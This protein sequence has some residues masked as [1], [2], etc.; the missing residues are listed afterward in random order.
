MSPSPPADSEDPIGSSDA[1]PWSC[2]D[3]SDAVLARRYRQLDALFH[4]GVVRDTADIETGMERERSFQVDWNRMSR[5]KLWRE[6]SGPYPAVYEGTVEEYM[7]GRISRGGSE[8]EKSPA[9]PTMLFLWPNGRNLKD[10]SI[11][12]QI[13][14]FFR[15]M[16]RH[17]KPY[18][19]VAMIL[20]MS[21]TRPLQT[22]IVSYVAQQ[23]E[24]NPTTVPIWLYLTSTFLEMISKTLYWWYEM[25]VPLN[26]Q[27]VQ[28][29]SVL[30][31]KRTSLP[32]DHPLAIKWP[33][34]RFTGLLKDVDDVVNNVW[35]SCLS[36]FDDLVSIIYLLILCFSNLA[37]ST[38][39]NT[40]QLQG[41]DYGTYVAVFVGFGLIT[42]GAPFLWFNML[43][44]KVQECE[45]MIREG[46]MIYMSCSADAVARGSES[47]TKNGRKSF[48][49]F[50]RTTFRSFFHRLAWTT[51]FSILSHF[52][53]ALAAY[54]LLTASAFGGGSLTSILI[55]LLSLKELSAMSP[56]VLDKLILMSRGCN[57]LRDVAEL[58]NADIDGGGA[59]SRSTTEKDV[60]E[61]LAHGKARNGSIDFGNAKQN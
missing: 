53:G 40:E 35:K 41:S 46:Q 23:I 44:G 32:D 10:L 6:E 42:M 20:L 15:F 5:N 16:W 33:A 39:S 49:I 52:L 61:G 12:G 59:A 55:V 58:M 8:T 17:T 19:T 2:K 36:I 21:V 30:L 3:D 29:R 56:K 45:T 1:G 60:E 4:E 22:A 57:S 25:W 38:N 7:Y 47:T 9:D 43:Y 27:R 13:Y 48:W 18:K 26:S 14:D 31:S 11:Y 50:G 28:M 51:N 34:G 37:I 54:G 24:S